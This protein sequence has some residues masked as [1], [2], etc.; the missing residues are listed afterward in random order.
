M[1]DLL[2]ICQPH[3]KYEDGDILFAF[4]ERRISSCHVEEACHIKRAPRERSG[5]C[6]R[7]TRQ[8]DL[9]AARYSHRIERDGRDFVRYINQ[10]TGDE[11][12]IGSEPVEVPDQHGRVRPMHMHVD[13]YFRFLLKNPRNRVFG[14][15]GREVCYGGKHDLPM[16]KLDVLWQRIEAETPLRKADHTHFPITPV[17]KRLFLPVRMG[18][19]S[20]A[21]ADDLVRPMLDVRNAEFPVKV[22]ERANRMD[23]AAAFA[24]R[25]AE[26]R[27]K[28]VP[29]DLR[30]DKP[31]TPTDLMPAKVATAEERSRVDTERASRIVDDETIRT[32]L[33]A[34]VRPR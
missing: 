16:A 33:S 31:I 29:V 5:H 3:A 24:D 12:I 34:G 8:E 13:E 6:V 25:L 15:A 14:T 21:E 18:P 10:A 19:M 26:I 27:D 22:R 2:L 7:G 28:R 1:A 30:E 32:R 17:E 23:Y 20:D 9:E 11:F 4:S